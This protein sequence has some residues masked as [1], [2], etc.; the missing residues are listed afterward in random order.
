[1]C[2]MLT[3]GQFKAAQPELAEAGQGLICQFGVALG[4]LG[5][6]R[7][8]GAPRVH[9]I[10]P[11][12]AGEGLYALITPSL[13]RNDLLRDGRYALHSYPCPENEDAFYITGR[14]RL[15]PNEVQRRELWAAY[16]GD[17]ERL[18]NTAAM[19]LG[20]QVIF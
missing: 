12:F 10:A 5:T 6:T 14:V 1:M 17:P 18:G 9:P 16:V 15:I 20:E 11:Q 19:D 8:D 13:K 3:W 4:F 7:K 2:A